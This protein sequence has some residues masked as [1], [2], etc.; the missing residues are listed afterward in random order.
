MFILGQTMV[1]ELILINVHFNIIQGKFLLMGLLTDNPKC[2]AQ[3][4]GDAFEV[5]PSGRTAMTLFFSF[6]RDVSIRTSY[7][8]HLF[9]SSDRTDDQV[10][11]LIF[12]CKNWRRPSAKPSNEMFQRE[13]LENASNTTPLTGW[14]GN[15]AS[16]VRNRRE[17]KASAQL[18]QPSIQ[19]LRLHPGMT[20]A[21]R[22]VGLSLVNLIYIIP[23]RHAQMVVSQ[24]VLETAK[25]I[26]STTHHTEQ[27]AHMEYLDPPAL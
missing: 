12:T 25:L 2:Y 5:T 11:P 4:W 22:E 16:T 21:H 23:Y 3:Q 7:P 20:A 18:T 9:C 24:M 26:I 17:G 15:M 14:R 10:N 8:F 27:T 6:H 13:K 19:S 1:S